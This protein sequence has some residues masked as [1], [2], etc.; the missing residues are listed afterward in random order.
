MESFPR[1]LAAGVN[2]CL[3]TDTCP[4]SMLH[5][6][7]WAAVVGKI[8]ARDSQQSTARD[9]FDAATLN[10]GRMLHRDDLGRIAPGAKADI[11]F[12]DTGSPFMVPLRDPIKNIVFNAEAEDLREVMIDGQW[13]V[14]DGQP[15]RVDQRAA[16]ATLQDEAER[17]WARIGPGDWAGR[18]V[19][20]IAPQTYRPFES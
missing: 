12:W 6:L 15:V 20:Q 10:P 17:L 13:V 9:V 16:A 5:A 18:T 2:V 7:R 8:A 11:L 1:Y 3:G 19:D 4:L 14:R